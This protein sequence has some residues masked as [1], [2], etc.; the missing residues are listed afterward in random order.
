MDSS[1]ELTE[2]DETNN[3][4]LFSQGMFVAADG[5]RKR[6][7]W[8]AKTPWVALEYEGES[9]LTHVIVDPDRKVTLDQDLLNNAKSVSPQTSWRVL[10][11]LTYWAEVWLTGLGS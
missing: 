7:T 1:G 3:E 8:D 6:V 2:T 4:Q 5:T 9:P 10:E 11:R